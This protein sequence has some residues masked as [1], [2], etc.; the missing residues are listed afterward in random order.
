L[1][2]L[3]A[4][5]PICDCARLLKG[6]SS[7]WVNDQFFTDRSFAWQEGNGAF[8]ISPSLKDATVAYI[9]NQEEHHRVR[10]FQNEYRKF[11]KRQG[12]V[13]DERHMWG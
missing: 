7:K 6:T 8:P 4:D 11:L 9:E 5:R 12:I 1:I 3:P 2:S 10:T 13:W